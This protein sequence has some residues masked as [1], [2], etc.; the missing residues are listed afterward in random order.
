MKFVCQCTERSSHGSPFNQPL[1]GLWTDFIPEY[2]SLP[3]RL[4]CIVQYPPSWQTLT[5]TQWFPGQKNIAMINKVLIEGVLF[6][7]WEHPT[8]TTSGRPI[9]SESAIHDDW[10]NESFIK[11]VTVSLVGEK[12]LT[13][14]NKIVKT[15]FTLIFF[16]VFKKYNFS[17]QQYIT[18]LKM[19]SFGGRNFRV[20]FSYER[21]Q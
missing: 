9:I 3:V 13:K 5:L 1:C 16:K 20:L 19:L 17:T 7:C 18:W 15:F 8:I 10:R 6:D 14:K 11:D 2:C 21:A 4:Q 12:K